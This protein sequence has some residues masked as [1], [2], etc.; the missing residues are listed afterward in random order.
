MS[1]MCNCIYSILTKVQIVLFYKATCG[2]CKHQCLWACLINL[3]FVFCLA[4]CSIE[5]LHANLLDLVPFAVFGQLQAKVVIITTPNADFN[6]L[7]PDLQ[8]FRHWDHKFEWTREQ[9]RSW[10][11]D[12]AKKFNYNVEYC[13][14]GKGPPGS[15]ETLGWCSQIAV[16]TRLHIDANRTRCIEENQRPYK[17][18]N[19]ISHPHGSRSSRNM[20]RQLQEELAYYC[21][22]LADVS[23]D[24]DP[25]EDDQGHL[26]YVFHIPLIR[27]MNFKNITE[28]CKD[29]DDLRCQI[30]EA[31][32]FSLSSDG[33][34]VVY[35]RTIVN[36]GWCDSDA[37][38]SDNEQQEVVN[39]PAEAETGET[40]D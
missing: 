33:K 37:N 32:Q 39:I 19:Q 28:L 1:E 14:V 15:L 6:V 4:M 7:F 27:L 35:Q 25:V 22:L 16:F 11:D 24:M 18:I 38:Q 23:D 3:F 31:G 2:Y 29:V 30:Q 17:C 26:T 20:L 40:W 10:C 12:I 13:G 21:N 5:H 36:R 34:N 9:F 8:G